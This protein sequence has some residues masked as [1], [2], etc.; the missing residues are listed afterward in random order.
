MDRQAYRDEIMIRL[1][2]GVIDLELSTEALDRC[3]DSAFRQVQRYIDTTV[4]QT[5]P[6]SSCI[7]LTGCG[8][9]SVVRVF[10]TEGY[11]TSN[12]DTVG[13]TTLDPM[14]MSMWQS[15]GGAGIAT[16][17][18]TK[19]TEN[20]AAFNTSLQIRNTLSTDLIFRYDKHTNWLYINCGYDKPKLI[21]IEFVPKYTDVSQVVSD[22]WIDIIVRLSLAICKQAIGRIR[23]KFTQDNALWQ[24]DTDI[25]TEGLEEEKELQEALRK[26]SQLVY[27]LD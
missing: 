10:R 14:Y 11:A 27:P 13:S 2:G 24:L 16:S 17:A 26:A 21:T 1:T 6:Y 8:V 20:L 23:K 5:I 4:L 22:Y 18:M 12:D 3:I 9:S 19:W 15:L 25:L 7:D